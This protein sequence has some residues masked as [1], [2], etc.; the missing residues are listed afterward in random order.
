MSEVIITNV[1]K[2]AA[3]LL[4]VVIEIIGALVLN[5]LKKRTELSNVADAMGQVTA[6]AQQT[7]LE[8]QQTVVDD[9][10]AGRESGKLTPAEIEDL[11]QRL[12]SG[13]Y[14]KM[15][16]SVEQLLESAG[17]DI[18]QLIQSSGE[19]FINRVIK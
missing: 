12:V 3:A 15:S 4:V 18:I 8:L 1:V 6:M 19:A 14:A 10:K 9:I 7:V 16:D 5:A 11:G 13:V 2:I 17:V